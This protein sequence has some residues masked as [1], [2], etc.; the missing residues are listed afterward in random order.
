MVKRVSIIPLE[1][2]V[3][4]IAAGSMAKRLG[5]E[6][7]YE[8]KR[9]V[10]EFSYKDDDL[11]DPMVNDYHV[12]AMGYATEEEL[13]TIKRYAMQINDISFR[14]S[15]RS[16][17]RAGR[18]Q[19]G[20]RQRLPTAPSYWRTRFPRIPAASGMQRL[21][22]SWIRTDSEEISAAWKTPIRKS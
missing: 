6:E 17:H 19:A 16:G 4:N 10:L 13:D 11:G 9:P 2:I 7:G 8:L 5:I 14:I 20:V 12:L 18:L 22:R 3:R 21:T 1:V 15:E